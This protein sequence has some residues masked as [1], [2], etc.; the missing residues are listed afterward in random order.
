[1][2]ATCKRGH[3]LAGD[4]TPGKRRQCPACHAIPRSERTR[5]DAKK[6]GPKPLT[7]RA[8]TL[9]KLNRPQPQLDLPPLLARKL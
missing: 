9:R 2:T 7:S 4:Y 6:P 5:P 3:I 1:M 8:R